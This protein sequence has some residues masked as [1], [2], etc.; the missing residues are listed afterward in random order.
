MLRSGERAPDFE[1]PDQ[2]SRARSLAELLGGGP[3]ILYFYPAD[4]TPGCTREACDLRDLHG[5]I[6]SAGLR[7]VGVSPQSPDS[8][9]RFR[10]QHALP[11]TLLSDEAKTAIR[12][13]DVD[14]PLGIGAR[15]ATFL[16]DRDRRI[17][18]AVLADLRIG[19]HQEFVQRAI[20][21]RE[22]RSA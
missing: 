9:R 10:E 18:D 8:H 1:L 2:D 15:R 16:I 3:L 5:L 14:G 6:L 20:D 11:F 17:A 22:N 21:V 4:F 13:Y 12:A 7:V 19:R